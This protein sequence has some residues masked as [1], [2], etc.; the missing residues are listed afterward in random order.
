VVGRKPEWWRRFRI[1]ATI[2]LVSL[3]VL[4][5]ALYLFNVIDLAQ[6]VLWAFSTI[7]IVYALRHIVLD[8]LSTKR[9]IDRS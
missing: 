8:V 3:S 5:V 7:F 2:V 1:E 9:S 4:H 6:A